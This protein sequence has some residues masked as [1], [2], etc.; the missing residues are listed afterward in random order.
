MPPLYRMAWYGQM[1]S[2][3]ARFSPYVNALRQ[4]VTPDSVVLDIG[5]GTGIFALL[6]CQFGAR[7]VYAVEPAN[8]I[9]LARKMANTNGYADRIVFLQALSTQL[10]LPEPADIIV[11]DLRGAFPLFHNHIPTIIDARQ[12]LLAPD[13]ILIPQRDTLWAAVVCV[14]EFYQEL[15]SAWQENVYDLDLQA[16]LPT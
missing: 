2:N 1:I 6:A 4:A 15:T 10:T 5:T 3:Q 14:P 8:A 12:R 16:G 11:S 7:R 13:G 9:H